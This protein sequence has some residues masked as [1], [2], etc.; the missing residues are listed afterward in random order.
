M[1]EEHFKTI[2]ALQVA[3]Q[4]E[5]DGKQYYQKASLES[6]NRVGRELFQ[7]LAS[8]EDRHKQRF[9][10]IYKAIENKKA[11]PQIDIQPGRQKGLHTLFAEAL[12]TAELNL[13]AHPTELDAIA[14]AMYMENKTHDFYKTQAQKAVH[15]TERSLYEAIAT[16]ER[17]HYLAL[18]DYRE[19][20]I[21]P[22][23]W[24]RKIE[25][26]SLDGG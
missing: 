4:M 6:S 18:A 24:F 10:E 11:W 7:W 5:I 21:D 25:R 20:I 12:K 2:Q 14:K 9:E 1:A 22:A 15:S 19:Y 3:I 26:H 13:K 23:G 16:E 17:G 8:E